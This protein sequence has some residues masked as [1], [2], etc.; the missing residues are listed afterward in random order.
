M[1][2]ATHKFS[3]KDESRDQTILLNV[4]HIWQNFNKTQLEP[5]ALRLPSP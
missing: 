1:S 3:V 4:L 5:R 2:R